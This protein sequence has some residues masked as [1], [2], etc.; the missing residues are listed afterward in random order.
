MGRGSEVAYAPDS[1]TVIRAGASMVYD[2]YGNDLAANIASLGSLGLASEPRQYPV[3]YN[4]TTAPRY[5]G[6]LPSLPSAPTGGFPFTP[7]LNYAITAPIY[8]IFPDLVAPY[9]FLLNA[10][11]SLTNLR[12]GITLDVGYVGRLSHKGLLEQNVGQPL[13]NFKDNKS[14]MTFIQA[15]T[16]MRLLSDSGV[17]PAQVKANPSLV[18]TNAFAE[19]MF[20]GLKNY[21]FPGSASANYFYNIYGQFAGSDLDALHALGSRNLRRFPQLYRGDG[22]LYVLRAPVEQWRFLV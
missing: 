3:S 20:P 12:S 17:T 8:G 21:Y 19:D 15:D 5:N 10:S 18:A 22:V 9:S 6:S 1:K 7:L 13:L 14:G 2:Q 16:A 11:V 4:F